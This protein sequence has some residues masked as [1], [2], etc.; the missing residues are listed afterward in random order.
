M[1][2]RGS[3]CL[4]RL[5][6]GQFLVK[7]SQLGPNNHE[8][9]RTY[10]E[11]GHSSRSVIVRHKSSKRRKNR[12]GELIEVE[13]EGGEVE[14]F[15]V[16]KLEETIHK[17]AVKRAAPVW[18]PFRPG[19]SYWVPPPA[20]LGDIIEIAINSKLTDEDLQSFST[21]RRGWPSID[22]YIN[23]DESSHTVETIPDTIEKSEEDEE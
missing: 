7:T 6:R 13:L 2:L 16:K 4:T 22:Y 8:L 3:P 21:A 20:K 1:M 15:A 23:K 18:L 17:M 14:A 9:G 10:F 5:M 19:M 11:S 12:R